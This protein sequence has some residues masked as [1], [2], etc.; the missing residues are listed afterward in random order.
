MAYQKL[1]SE[2]II[3]SITLPNRIVVPAMVTRLSGEDGHINQDI[4][5]R[6]LRFSKG[7]AGLIVLEAMAVHGSK[8]GPLLRLSDDEF[9]PGLRD[10]TSKMRDAGPGKVAPQI[11]HFLKISRSGWRQKVKDLSII[12]IEEIPPFYAQAARRAQQAGCDGVEL[13]MAH[14]YTLSSFLSR[15]NGRR[16][17][18]GGSL[19]KRLR[20]PLDVVA[21]VRRAVGDSFPVGVRFDG[22]ECVRGG[23]TV[24]EAK[25]IAQRLSSA[26][27]D[28]ISIS[29][30][31]KF[32]DAQ[33][34]EGEPLYPY[35]GYSGERCMPGKNYPD[36]A[37]L[38]LAEA[39]KGHLLGLDDKTPVL[40]AGK[41]ST[42]DLA[43]HIL[44]S[45]KADMIG[46]ARPILADPSWPRKVQEGNWDKVVRCCYANVCKA[47][48]EKFRTVTCYLWPKGNKQ[49]PESGDLQPPEWPTSG[50]SLTAV[51]ADGKVTLKWQAA[52]DNEDVHGYDIFRSSG[53]QKTRRIDAVPGGLTTYHDTTAVAGT[54]YTYSVQAFDLAGNRSRASAKVTVGQM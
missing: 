49:A 35:T 38:Y 47:L 32:E 15:L 2:L 28:Y 46:M 16:D 40:A 29:A 8:S 41:I 44:A 18:Y 39:I 50:A 22:E 13:H 12:E 27:C 34:R 4:T 5:D 42:P 54:P 30:G 20:L 53:I 25:V 19:E 21:A 9:V 37:N 43:E 7:H 48:D 33:P 26:S 31:G 23:Y 1:F 14:A 6:Y 51:F 52:T 10:L 36:G 11:I 24:E 45:G 3:N 17:D